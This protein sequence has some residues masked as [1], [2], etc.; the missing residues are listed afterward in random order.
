MPT[1]DYHQISDVLHVI[2]QVDPE[3]VL[4]VG[5]GFGKWGTLCREILEIYRDR[6]SPD[7]WL[8]QI[9]GIEIFEAYRN[10]LWG[11]AYDNIH[12]GNGT[13]IIERL[14]KYDL[15]LCCDVIE[16]FEKAEGEIFLRKLLEH[17][18]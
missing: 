3:S 7:T 1:S 5:V 13:E 11:F 17:G 14:G 6:V 12:I 15:I 8:V 2:E 10:E 9:D 4:E 18:S 16:H